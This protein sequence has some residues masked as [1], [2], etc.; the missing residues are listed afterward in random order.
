MSCSPST[1]AADRFGR[2][3]NYY[4][5]SKRSVFDKLS[6]KQFSRKGE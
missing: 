4:C 3:S 5:I 1:Y 6:L 2:L